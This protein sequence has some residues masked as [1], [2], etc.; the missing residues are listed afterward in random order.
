MRF[1]L[2]AILV[3]FVFMLGFVPFNQKKDLV[4]KA[5]YEN[6]FNQVL[7]PLNWKNW[8]QDVK[9][10]WQH[11]STQVNITA[12][13]TNAAIEAPDLHIETRLNGF[14]LAVEKSIKKR[15]EH[16]SFTLQIDKNFKHT[17]IH[18][19]AK[20]NGFKW[21]MLRLNTKSIFTDLEALKQYLE[22]DKAYYGFQIN[23]LSTVDTNI[24]VVKKTVP[25]K[26]K[27][28]AIVAA[29]NHLQAYI[30]L[31]HYD[32]AQ[33][34]IADIH[35]DYSGDSVRIMMGIPIVQSP[36]PAGDVVLMQMPKQ[37]RQISIIYTGKYGNRLAC[38]NSLKRYIADHSLATPE[39][40]YEK[41][42]DNKIPLNNNDYTRMQ[43]IFPVQ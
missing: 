12:K 15:N 29:Q 19:T 4:I 33:P 6:V 17:D 1:F 11:D 41:Y 7:K 24:L 31:H 9:A 38:Y 43:I 16:Y 37:N 34:V 10:A 23:D 36:K 5:K 20:T 27:N 22:D 18:L 21:L 28:S 25:L 14:G 32:V 2:W 26:N 35:A 3:L 40:P 42:L 8:Q 30:S 39:V 13:G